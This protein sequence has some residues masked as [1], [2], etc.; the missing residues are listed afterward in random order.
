MRVIDPN[1]GIA[2][3]LKIFLTVLNLYVKDGCE[4][5]KKVKFIAN[6]IRLMR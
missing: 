1:T 5:A 3:L 2:L 4:I 6:G